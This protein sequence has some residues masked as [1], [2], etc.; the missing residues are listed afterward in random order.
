MELQFGLPEQQAALV[1]A[2]ADAEPNR[3]EVWNR[4]SKIPAN[5]RDSFETRLKKVRRCGGQMLPHRVCVVAPVRQMVHI[6][7]AFLCLS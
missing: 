4:V 2:V 7:Q 6:R 3:G 5:A 1:A